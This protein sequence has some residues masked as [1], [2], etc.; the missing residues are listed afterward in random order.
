MPLPMH[1]PRT[2]LVSRIISENAL[3][4]A[5]RATL[6]R[7]RLDNQRVG[8]VI[9]LLKQVARDQRQAEADQP[10]ANGALR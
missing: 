8:D 3:P 4:T 6:P 1:S 7:K 5:A 2:R 9:E 10:G